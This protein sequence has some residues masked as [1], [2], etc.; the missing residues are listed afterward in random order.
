MKQKQEK[1]RKTHKIRKKRTETKIDE[2]RRNKNKRN[3]RK[4]KG[5][6][7]RR[8]NESNVKRMHKQSKRN[9][10]VSQHLVTQI[11]LFPFRANPGPTRQVGAK[12]NEKNQENQPK[13][14]AKINA[15][16]YGLF[17]RK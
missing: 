2:T 3:K 12:N 14:D 16:K 11:L 10:Q 1:Q 13:I 8:K 15:E 7:N 6:T 17:D 4:T 9:A 5:N